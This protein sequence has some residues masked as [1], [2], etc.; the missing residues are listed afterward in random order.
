MVYVAGRKTEG[1]GQA[2]AT[3][4]KENRHKAFSMK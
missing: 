2:G 4:L 1:E 3:S